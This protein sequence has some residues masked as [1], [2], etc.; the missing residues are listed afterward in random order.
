MIEGCEAAWRFFGGVFR[1]LVPDNAAGGRIYGSTQA[2]PVEVFTEH[3]A[4]ALLPVP[5]AKIKNLR[6][7]K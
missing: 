2:R 6:L 3:E 5:E 4:A 1:A 7:D